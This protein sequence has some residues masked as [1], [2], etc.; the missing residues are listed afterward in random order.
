[1][2]WTGKERPWLTGQFDRHER[3]GCA[4]KEAPFQ[5][6][7]RNGVASGLRSEPAQLKFLTALPRHKL[8]WLPLTEGL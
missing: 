7:S 8:G 1:M 2:I 6:G 5:T 4:D 3:L